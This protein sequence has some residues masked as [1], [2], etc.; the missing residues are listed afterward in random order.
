MNTFA[1]GQTFNRV[2]SIEMF[3]HMRNWRELFNRIGS[4]LEPGGRFFL[5]T[6]SHRTTPYSYVD[7]GEGD[8]MARHFFT[9]GMMPSHQLATLFS[10][11]T[12][13]VV[14][15]HRATW[16]LES[17]HY[18]RTA[19]AWLSNFDRHAAEI[20]AMFRS[21]YGDDANRWFVRWR[22]FFL[23]CAGMFGADRGESWGV[24][25]HLFGKD[26]A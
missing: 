23:A 4:W 1:P 26:P 21:V 19:E 3:E 15:Q 25:H 6:F 11:R 14:L 20:R 9:G 18:A 2:V 5:H 10:A 16:W 8:W 12:T 7:R 24:S 22:I 17:L 13:E